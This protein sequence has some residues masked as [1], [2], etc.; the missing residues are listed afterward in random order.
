[1]VCVGRF[2][3]LDSSTGRNVALKL[4]SR[5]EKKDDMKKMA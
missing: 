1:M 4:R 3:C 5:L 2:I